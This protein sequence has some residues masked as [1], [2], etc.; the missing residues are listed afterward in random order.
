MPWNKIDFTRDMIMPWKKTRFN[1]RYDFALEK[2]E[3]TQDM[4][5]HWKNRVNSRYDYALEKK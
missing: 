5:F 2:T 1:S 3:L 4:I